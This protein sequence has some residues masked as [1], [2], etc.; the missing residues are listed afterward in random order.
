M[1][2]KCTGGYRAL[3]DAV[4]TSGRVVGVD[5]DQKMVDA[6]KA[7][8]HGH[9][10]VAIHLADGHALPFAD[11]TFDRGPHGSRPPARRRPV[12]GPGRTPARAQAGRAARLAEQAGFEVEAVYSAAPVFRDFALAD[13][14]F[15]FSRNT[16][17]AIRAGAI[18]RADGGRW[19]AELR[20]GDFFAA[21][22]MFLLVARK[23]L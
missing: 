4:T 6:A 14:I 22:L 1:H 19:L 23:P 16:E 10:H 15:A 2:T 12:R 17:R 20:T 3:A 9:P 21:P 8:F 18:D 7:R 11:A 13:T 5:I